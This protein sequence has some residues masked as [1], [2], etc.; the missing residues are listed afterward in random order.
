M[1]KVLVK[2]KK[3]FNDKGNSQSRAKDSEFL[4]KKEYAEKLI[5]D[6]YVTAVKEQKTELTGKAKIKAEQSKKAQAYNE[7]MEKEAEKARQKSRQGFEI[8]EKVKKPG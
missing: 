3:E 6:G 7:N 5:K 8:I 2:A 1:A 4:V